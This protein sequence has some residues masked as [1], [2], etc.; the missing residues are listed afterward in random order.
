MS[1][2]ARS[3]WKTKQV[4]SVNFVALSCSRVAIVYRA[5]IVLHQVVYVYY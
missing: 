1:G 2:K 5:D 4:I 3:G